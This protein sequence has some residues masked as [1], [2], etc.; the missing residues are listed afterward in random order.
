MQEYEL[1][2]PNGEKRF[3]LLHQRQILIGRS[4]HTLLLIQDIDEINADK[5]HLPSKK[6]VVNSEH[7]LHVMIF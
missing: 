4:I 2:L 6:P 7:V 1:T 5:M 3:I